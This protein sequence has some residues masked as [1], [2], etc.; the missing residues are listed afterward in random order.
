M[1]KKTLESLIFD[2]EI[3]GP[4]SALENYYFSEDLTPLDN[5]EQTIF[6]RLDKLCRAC[7]HVGGSI[8]MLGCCTC[9]K[10]G[11]KEK[12]WLLPTGP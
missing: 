12:Y 3:L 1:E 10:C 4:K 7:G 9:P 6:A 11:A 5:L 2:V 8:W